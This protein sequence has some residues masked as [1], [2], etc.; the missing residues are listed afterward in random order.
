MATREEI[1]TAI[2]AGMDR[3]EAVFS[4]LTDEQLATPVHPDEGGW[5]AR[6]ILAHLA[7]R[8]MGIDG[9]FGIAAGGASP[10]AGGFDVDQWNRDR[11]KE[12]SG[13]SRDELL[14]EF[15][16]VHTALIERVR[17]TP[18]GQFAV[19]VESPRG[20]A[21]LGDMLAGSGGRHSV[22]HADEVAAAVQGG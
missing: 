12:R 3:V 15:R 10:F 17:Q 8:Q 5:T 19:T 4:P 13:R 11:I 1:I 9:M 16:S 20:P 21:T 7:G 18:D 2:R 14:D 6:D 22:T